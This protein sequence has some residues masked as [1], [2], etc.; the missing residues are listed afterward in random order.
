MGENC[1]FLILYLFHD[2]FMFRKTFTSCYRTVILQ[3]FSINSLLLPQHL[4]PCGGVTVAE[5]FSM[6]TAAP[7]LPATARQKGDR[8]STVLTDL[9]FSFLLPDRNQQAALFLSFAE[10]DMFAFQFSSNAQMV[11]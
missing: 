8:T 3:R 5:S 11:I 10:R 6:K 1:Y 2:N 9:N 4:R 7:Y